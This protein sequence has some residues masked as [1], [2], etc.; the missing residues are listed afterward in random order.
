MFV[1]SIN[2]PFVPADDARSSIEPPPIRLPPKYAFPVVVAPPE[3]VSPPVC[4]PEPMVE[5]AKAVRPP[6]NC[7]RVEVELLVPKNGYAKEDPPVEI[8]DPFILKQPARIST[9]LAIVVVPVL[10]T[11]NSVVVALAVEDA[12]AKRVVAV[13][14]LLVW[15]ANFAHGVVEPMPSAPVVGRTKPVEVAGNDPKMSPPMFS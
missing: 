12:M 11:E 2:K 5:E 8:Q 4:E 6:L 9:P 3:M 7:V 15:I 1:E 13:S 10:E 14:P